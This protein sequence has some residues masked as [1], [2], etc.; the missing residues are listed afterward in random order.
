M[1]SIYLFIYL[2]IYPSL[3][4][5]IGNSFWAFH[6]AP[7][8]IAALSTWAMFADVDKGGDAAR[9]GAPVAAAADTGDAASEPDVFDF[10]DD[11]ASKA[12]AGSDAESSSSSSAS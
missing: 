11:D 4:S 3:K 2:S 10:E 6:F 8:L 1:F 7:V 9:T 5:Y 12:A